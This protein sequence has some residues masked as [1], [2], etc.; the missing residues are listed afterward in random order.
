M[1]EITS[2]PYRPASAC[3]RCCFGRGAHAKW[4]EHRLD[5]RLCR[6]HFSVLPC[7]RCDPAALRMTPLAASDFRLPFLVTLE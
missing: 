5:V 7:W 6:A 4:C 2:R 3:E 1:S